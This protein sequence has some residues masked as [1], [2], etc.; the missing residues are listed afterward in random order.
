MLLLADPR[1]LLS[2]SCSSL[3]ALF[4]SAGDVDVMLTADTHITAT[5][6]SQQYELWVSIG[7]VLRVHITADSS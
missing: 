6:G 4:C 1:A 7:L 3:P 2:D 5:V